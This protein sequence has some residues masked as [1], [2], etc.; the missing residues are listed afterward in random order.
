MPSL[1]DVYKKFGFA[2]E[3]AQLLETELGT[4]LLISG[5]IEQNLIETQDQDV[6]NT[7][8]P[9]HRTERKTSRLVEKQRFMTRQCLG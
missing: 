9:P 1:E 2:S 7:L 5:A 8:C 6:A 3:A 4:I